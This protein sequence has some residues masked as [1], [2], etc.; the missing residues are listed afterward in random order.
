MT[1]ALVGTLAVAQLQI[2]QHNRVDLKM[3]ETIQRPYW[4]IKYALPAAGRWERADEERDVFSQ[5][6]NFS[7][8]RAEVAYR[9]DG[10]EGGPRLLVIG[11]RK[12]KS[13]GDLRELAVEE[14]DMEPD[15][16]SE[17]TTP[18]G[19]PGVRS[20]KEHAFGASI[21]AVLKLPTGVAV[22]VGY[23]TPSS[24]RREMPLFDEICRNVSAV[25]T[26]D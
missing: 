7:L 3:G 17:Y 4:P 15:R 22:Y 11:F 12:A 14:F 16:L 18:G 9:G 1:L 24:I 19:I 21:Q 23:Q 8:G 25:D 2:E 6:L 5:F 20:T 26:G 10:M 13:N